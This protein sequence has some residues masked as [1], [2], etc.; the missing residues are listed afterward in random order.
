MVVAGGRGLY[1]RRCHAS[2]APETVV[3]AERHTGRA[4]QCARECG[5]RSSRK[6]R[7]EVAVRFGPGRRRHARRDHHAR[8]GS[9][10]CRPSPERPAARVAR[11][12]RH[13]RHGFE[14][15]HDRYLEEH[16]RPR[17][18]PPRWPPRCLAAERQQGHRWN[19]HHGRRCLARGARHAW[20][21][22]RRRG[23]RSSSRARCSCGALKIRARGSIPASGD[24]R[25]V[26]HRTFR[27]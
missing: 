21:L 5:F 12:R 27:T 10:L 26:S 19:V 24:Q 23:A 18:P 1:D 11:A 6:P 15:R 25:A 20:P 8:P 9:A 13:C 17:S 14:R 22:A 3:H 2:A 4:G 7:S 16:P